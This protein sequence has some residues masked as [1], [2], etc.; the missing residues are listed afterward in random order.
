MLLQA[1]ADAYRANEAGRASEGLK[2]W[3]GGPFDPLGL[4]EDLDSLTELKAKETKNGRLAIMSMLA[5][6]V[7][8]IVPGEGPAETRAACTAHALGANGLSL[9]LMGQVTP[10]PLAIFAACGH[11]AAELSA[12]YG[13]DCSEWL[14]LE[15]PTSV[16]VTGVYPGDYGW[17]TADLG[18]GQ[19]TM[20][21][22]R[23][24]KLIHARWA[25]LDI[26]GCLALEILA[27]FT[28]S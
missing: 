6:A 22:Y 11:N 8:V 27:K 1:A 18:A 5:Y 21:Q 24:A 19:I 9:A 10:S 2:L 20:E 15:R 16:Y 26:M 25:L 4:A 28:C 17:G 12:W 14:V 3:P 7:Q 23:K 13:F